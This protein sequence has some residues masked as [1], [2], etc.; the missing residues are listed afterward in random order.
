LLR[1]TC[2]GQAHDFRGILFAAFAKHTKPIAMYKLLFLLSGLF[3]LA[4]NNQ[5]STAGGKADSQKNTAANLTANWSKEREMNFLSDCVENART[6]YNET[7]GYALCK[8]MLGQV[9]RKYPTADSAA[10]LQHLSDT[11]EV[12]KMIKDCK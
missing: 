10:L 6:L 5:S 3:L 2:S 11:A 1:A 7:Q 12:A 8:C 9:Q 4:C